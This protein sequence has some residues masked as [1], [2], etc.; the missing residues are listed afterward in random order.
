MRDGY[1]PEL[2]EAQRIEVERSEMKQLAERLLRS[3]FADVLPPEDLERRLQTISDTQFVLEKDFERLAQQYPNEVDAAGVMRV[4][5]HGQDVRRYAVVK[6][7][8]SRADTLHTLAHEATHLMAPESHRVFNPMDE[9]E[10]EQVYSVYIGPLCHD[11]FVH[12][13]KVDPM[14]IYFDKPAQ[15]ALFWEAVTDWHADEVLR[16]V[17]SDEEKKE[18]ET[19]GVSRTSLHRLSC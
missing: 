3:A 7:T 11:R 9:G 1:S 13:G 16:D 2:L 8:D 15:R 5:V 19:G 4:E 17:L 18:V 10:D 6:Q 12:N 14:S